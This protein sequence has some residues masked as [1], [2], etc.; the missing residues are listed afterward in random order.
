MREISNHDYSHAQKVWKAFN[1][2]NLGEYHDFYLKTD[3]LLPNNVS[4]AF[5]STCLKHYNLDPAHFYIVQVPGPKKWLIL[6]VS[7]THLVEGRDLFFPEA[8]IVDNIFQ[9]D[10]LKN[11]RQIKSYDDMFQ[12]TEALTVKKFLK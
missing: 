7:L 4:E 12:A 11:I 2:R 3:V 8:E 10:V 6:G 9:W 1:I 5:R